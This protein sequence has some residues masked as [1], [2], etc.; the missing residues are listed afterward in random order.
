MVNVAV[1]DHPV[2]FSPFARAHG[3]VESALRLLREAEKA[4]EVVDRTRRRGAVNA[5][6]RVS[7][8][9][10]LLQR[11]YD[12]VTEANN[13]LTEVLYLYTVAA[14]GEFPVAVDVLSRQIV[15][16][17]RAI[18][19][20][21]LRL[22]A[23]GEHAVELWKNGVGPEPKVEPPSRPR[24]PRHSLIHRPVSVADRIEALFQ[25]RR[26]S[27]AAAPEEVPRKPSRGRAPP[28]LEACSL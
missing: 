4:T 16:L 19:A 18:K 14:D 28:F 27:K 15:E 22:N 12:H 5:N 3:R 6:H 25:R 1:L 11:A 9:L 10:D 8:A 24:P 7:R 13:A 2:W 17:F 26:R 21:A 23:A 20:M